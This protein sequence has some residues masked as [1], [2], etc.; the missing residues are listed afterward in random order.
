MIKFFRKI[1]QNMIKENKVSKYLLY[2]IGEILLVVIGILIALQI[3]SSNELKIQKE[4]ATTNLIQIHNELA[5]SINNADFAIEDYRRRDSLLHIILDNKVSFDDYKNDSILNLRNAISNYMTFH[6]FDNGFESL[7]LDLSTLP[8]EYASL[9]DDL[10]ALYKSNKEDVDHIN[11]KIGN[12][13]SAHLE[14]LRK[15]KTWFADYRYNYTASDENIAYFLS[16][17]FYKNDVAEFH[18]V[19]IQNHLGTIMWFRDNAIN[20]YSAITKTLGLEEKV[21][22]HQLEHLF[23]IKK[24]SHW[25]GSYIAGGE[26]KS[27]AGTPAKIFIENDSLFINIY[28]SKRDYIRIMSN[29]N[30]YVNRQSNIY[31]VKNDKNDELESFNFQGYKGNIEFKKV[32]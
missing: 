11:T 12:T 5:R 19:A 27:Q 28:N 7:M 10:K 25:Q 15:T 22:D 13:V 1:R 18:N 20:N 32:K 31:L 9:V 6:I 14:S 17:P 24:Y 8:M 3:N 29:G 30:F 26:E 23:D 16:D 2:A 21:T 4:K